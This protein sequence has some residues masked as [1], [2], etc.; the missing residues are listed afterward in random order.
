M[1]VQLGV[2]NAGMGR[3]GVVQVNQIQ[4]GEATCPVVSRE[5][6]EFWLE[7][8]AR[9]ENDDSV[10]RGLHVRLEGPEVARVSTIEALREWRSQ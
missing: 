9:M 8:E 4:R 6:E 10:P 5:K 3:V 2:Y 7:M 1:G